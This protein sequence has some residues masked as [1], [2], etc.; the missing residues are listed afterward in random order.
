[1]YLLGRMISRRWGRSWAQTWPTTRALS[2]TLCMRRTSLFCSAHAHFSIPAVCMCTTSLF[3]QCACAQLL[4][5]CSAHVHNFSISAV[6]MRTASLFLQCA[7]AQ[8]LY[9]C[10]AHA[11]SFSIS[12]VRMCTTSLLLQCA[13]AQ[14]LYFCSA[15]VHSFSISAVRMRT[16]SLFLQC[17][18]AQLLYFCSA[19]AH[20]FSISAVRMCTTSL[21]LQSACAQLLYFCS[22]HVLHSHNCSI[23]GFPWAHNCF[24][25]LERTLTQLLHSWVSLRTQLLYF[26]RAHAPTTLF[27]DFLAHTTPPFQSSEFSYINVFKHS[28]SAEKVIKRVAQCACAYW[29]TGALWCVQRTRDSWMTCK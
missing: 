29:F 9:F 2:G 14:L 4:Y 10:R 6:R 19:H 20:S 11:H 15:H 12:A 5:F 18:C 26:F 27:L 1:M 8:L 21:F 3:L 13:C 22:A 23:P 24:I 28:A 7:C 16:A 17:A 25:S